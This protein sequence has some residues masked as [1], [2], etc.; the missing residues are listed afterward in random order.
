MFLRAASE[1]LDGQ[2]SS[3]RRG[4]LPESIVQLFLSVEET[5]E[6]YREQDK[7]CSM[8]ALLPSPVLRVLW[9]DTCL[10]KALGSRL[11]PIPGHSWESVGLLGGGA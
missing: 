10:A 6:G 11:D 1:L 2:L 9:F 4:L 7:G 8:A 3:G 5:G